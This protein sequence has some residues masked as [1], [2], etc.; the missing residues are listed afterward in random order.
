MGQIVGNDFSENFSEATP[1]TEISLGRVS[2]R[3][4]TSSKTATLTDGFIDRSSAVS[5]KWLND[6]K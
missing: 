2:S 3:F 5:L 1:G 4:M 6:N